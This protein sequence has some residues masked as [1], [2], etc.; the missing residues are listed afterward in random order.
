MATA[1]VVIAVIVVI[2]VLVW[3]FVGRN[4]PEKTATHEPVVTH[5][6]ESDRLYGGS[7]RPAGPDAE[8]QVPRS[9][10]SES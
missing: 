10:P 7:D 6:S 2:A 8:S 1:V 9:H 3:M 4:D 5:E